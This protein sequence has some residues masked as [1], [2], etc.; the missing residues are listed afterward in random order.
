LRR[1]YTVNVIGYALLKVSTMRWTDRS[2]ENSLHCSFCG[3]GQKE[4]SKLISSPSDRPRAYIC[5]ECVA[6]CS[7]IIEDDNIKAENPQAEEVL[8]DGEALHP[9]LE[10]PLASN[11]M[12]AIASWI[13]EQSLGNDGLLAVAEVRRIASRMLSD[14][15]EKTDA[16][17]RS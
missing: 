15:R 8:Y 4:A 2:C 9:L 13:R 14:D 11:L 10:H 1:A 5:D 16:R 17:R 7:T 3:K 6:I 12:E